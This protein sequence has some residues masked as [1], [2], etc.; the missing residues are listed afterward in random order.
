MYTPNFLS[1]FVYEVIFNYFI[2]VYY[3]GFMSIILQ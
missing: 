2:S 3:V 1:P